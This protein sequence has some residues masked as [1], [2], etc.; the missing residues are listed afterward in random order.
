MAVLKEHGFVVVPR[1]PSTTPD[2]RRKISGLPGFSLIAAML[3]RRGWVVVPDARG[4]HWPAG[5]RSR[6]PRLLASA[7]LAQR[8]FGLDWPEH[9]ETMAG[10]RRLTNLR[11][12]ACAVVEEDIPGDLIETG[13]WRGGSAILM[14]AVLGACGDEQRRVWVADSFSGL[15]S[16][17]P[18]YPADAGLDYSHERVLA[19]SADQVR[20]NFQRYGLLDERVR[21][22]EGLFKD[23]L[24]GAPIERLSLMRLDGDLYESTMD[25]LTALYPRLSPGGFCIIDDY[26]ALE[27]CRRAVHDFRTAHGIA[28]PIVPIDWTG[29]YWRRQH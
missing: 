4:E 18:D 19:V 27:A 9:A 24:P 13:V 14:R 29:V 21:F 7:A 22:L 16:P 17:S 5:T 23:T 25:A 10:L 2:A 3:R 20:A 6:R 11:E 26:G 28:D 8:E 1:L 12:L 15:P